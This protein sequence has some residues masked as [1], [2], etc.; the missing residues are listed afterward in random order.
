M[1]LC[2]VAYRTYCLTVTLQ[3]PI[4]SH[5][6][7][8]YDIIRLA[9]C[10]GASTITAFTFSCMRNHNVLRIP[11]SVFPLWQFC[12]VY[13][14]REICCIKINT[15]NFSLKNITIP[16]STSTTP[17]L[18]PTH[19]WICYFTMFNN[20]ML[21][22]IVWTCCF[23][24]IGSYLV[25][26]S[27]LPLA[28][29]AGDFDGDAALLPLPSQSHPVGLQGAEGDLQLGPRE[30]TRPAVLRGDLRGVEHWRAA[31]WALRDHTWFVSGLTMWAGPSVHTTPRQTQHPHLCDW[32]LPTHQRQRL[33]ILRT[34][35]SCKN[36]D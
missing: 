4:L 23:C 12:F 34:Y 13:I 18:K 7:T 8:K 26:L 14:N 15:A 22:E 31:G 3:R 29:R 27:A 25:H 2:H 28:W 36:F 16:W 35:V 9:F 20:R 10:D 32:W 24:L 17:T 6:N 5:E 1:K 11:C 33:K 21:L 30:A 19:W